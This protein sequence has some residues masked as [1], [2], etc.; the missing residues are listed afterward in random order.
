MLLAVGDYTSAKE[1]YEGILPYIEAKNDNGEL[2]CPRYIIA[3]ACI[4]AAKCVI[5]S[6][7]QGPAF[8]YLKSALHILSGG[9][10]MLDDPG[11]DIQLNYVDPELDTFRSRAPSFFVTPDSTPNELALDALCLAGKLYYGSNSIDESKKTFILCKEKARG[12]RDVSA[13]KAAL[14]NL[15]FLAMQEN[16]ESLA[17][18]YQAEIDSL[19]TTSQVPSTFNS[20]VAGLQCQQALRRKVYLLRR[21]WCTSYCCFIYNWHNP[22]SW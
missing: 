21:K 11:T 12:L 8:D 14:V 15:K 9:T 4:N 18:Q 17:N 16:N 13:E 7:V 5:D 3:E 19:S 2:V 6:G 22:G 20:T 10:F 1:S